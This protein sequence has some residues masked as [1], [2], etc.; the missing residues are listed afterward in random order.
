MRGRMWRGLATAALLCACVD[1]HG[2]LMRFSAAGASGG[3]AKGEKFGMRSLVG[4][5]SAGIPVN[6][7]FRHGVGFWFADTEIK[8]PNS[9]E[10][11]ETL[12][13]DV[14]VRFE[15]HQNYPNPFNPSTTIEFDLATPSR[16]KVEVFNI[17]GQ[18]MAL[19]VNE[20][21]AVGRHKVAWN[22]TDDSGG[23]ASSGVYLYRINAGDFVRTRT[24]TLVK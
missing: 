7:D 11:T 9:T 4:Q 22:A 10:E 2:Q 3:I 12:P 14:P 13:P 19:L 18:R 17:L 8:I 24:M 5:A 20:L 1:A 6:D 16:V 21:L 15:L 23:P